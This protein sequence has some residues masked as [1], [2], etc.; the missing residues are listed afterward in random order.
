MTI[1]AVFIKIK[2][3]PVT[4][5][6]VLCICL[7]RHHS[8]FPERE[9]AL[10]LVFTDKET[11]D[12]AFCLKLYKAVSIYG[13][14][15]GLDRRIGHPKPGVTRE[16]V[17]EY[18]EK[19][20]AFLPHKVVPDSGDTILWCYQ[21]IGDLLEHGMMELYRP[22]GKPAPWDEFKRE[23]PMPFPDE[24]PPLARGVVALLTVSRARRDRAARL[25]LP[26]LYAPYSSG[27]EREHKVGKDMCWVGTGGVRRRRRRG[28]GGVPGFT[29]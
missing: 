10:E 17:V 28:G 9:Y 5:Q 14:P 22:P 13:W 12:G 25:G 2:D 26:A 23:Y 20:S 7:V 19:V 3:H 6:C 29:H 16:Q 18:L 15:E 24:S 1:V 11:D 8:Q 27:V 4:N 21:A